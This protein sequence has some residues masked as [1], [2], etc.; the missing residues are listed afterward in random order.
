MWY[1]CGFTG[2]LSVT[3]ALCS[4]LSSHLFPSHF[5]R[6][7]IPLI[8]SLNYF[9]TECGTKLSLI[10]TLKLSSRLPLVVSKPSKVLGK[11]AI[12]CVRGTKDQQSLR[13]F[14][15]KSITLPKA[16]LFKIGVFFLFLS[17][18]SSFSPP[19]FFL[20]LFFS[21]ADVIPR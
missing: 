21:S 18:L 8:G 2:C 9:P 3:D 15:T 1:L 5:S 4:H 20:F 11:G 10:F 16:L 12:Y 6:I 14:F 19:L 17:L 13:L 7:H